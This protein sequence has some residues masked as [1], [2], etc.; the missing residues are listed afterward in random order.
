[1]TAFTT[2]TISSAT[3]DGM[4]RPDKSVEQ[5]GDTSFGY[6][7]GVDSL[8]GPPSADAAGPNRKILVAAAG[9]LFL[10]LVFVVGVVGVAGMAITGAGG[11]ADYGD[12]AG[13][14]R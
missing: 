6:I 3:L 5:Q 8:E 14:K 10:G 11:R 12:A 4:R 7:D 9:I 2:G 1:M 13:V